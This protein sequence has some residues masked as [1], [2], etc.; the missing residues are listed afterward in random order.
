MDGFIQLRHDGA[1]AKCFFRR[2]SKIGRDE[3]RKIVTDMLRRD[4]VCP[5]SKRTCPTLSAMMPPDT[6]LL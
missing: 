5:P 4:G 2:L 3:P 1:A 6:N